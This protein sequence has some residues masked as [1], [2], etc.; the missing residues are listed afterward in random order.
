MNCLGVATGAAFALLALAS[1]SDKSADSNGN[2]E[3]DSAERAA[4]MDYD[5]F[6]PMKAGLWETKFVFTDIDVPT[7]GKS[8]K[9]QIMDEV[10]KSSSSKSCLSEAEAKKPGANFFGGDGAEK[11]VYKAFDVA[12]QNVTMKLSCGME[13]MGSVDMELKGV[14]GETEFNYD[15]EV[16]IR[17]PMIG[18]VKMTGNAVGKHVGVCPAA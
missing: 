6:I 15:S 8:Q 16:A 14:M 2:G 17:L 11:C 4:E 13:G 3:V 10:A 9:K 7:L 18:R 1:C 12:G 5:A